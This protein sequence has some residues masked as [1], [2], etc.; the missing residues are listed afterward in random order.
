MSK[1]TTQ[2]WHPLER[3]ADLK[4]NAFASRM[5][6]KQ[7][8]KPGICHRHIALHILR[9]VTTYLCIGSYAMD[10]EVSYERQ[11]ELL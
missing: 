10:Y 3:Q 4:G 2:W 1:S 9:S 5:Q 11:K 7:F 8:Q 6:W